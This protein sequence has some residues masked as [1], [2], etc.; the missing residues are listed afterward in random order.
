MIL[1]KAQEEAGRQERAGGQDTTLGF[2]MPALGPPRF[3][4]EKGGAAIT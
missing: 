1:P 3:E 2:H 4:E